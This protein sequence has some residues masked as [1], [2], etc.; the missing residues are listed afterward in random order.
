M[1][2]LEE[3]WVNAGDSKPAIFKLFILSDAWPL[4]F[5]KIL[6][7]IF[8]SRLETEAKSPV[9]IRD[10]SRLPYLVIFFNIKVNS[11]IGIHIPKPRLIHFQNKSGLKSVFK[12]ILFDKRPLSF[13]F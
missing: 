6:F 1:F 12:D 2:G 8:L 13:I 5:S 3:V 4:D 7:F 10:F 9:G 11:G